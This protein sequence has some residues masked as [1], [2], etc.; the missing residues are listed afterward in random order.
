MYL[1]LE[2]EEQQLKLGSLKMTAVFFVRPKLCLRLLLAGE[3]GESRIGVGV[4]WKVEFPGDPQMRTMQTLRSAF[5]GS[6]VA[7]LKQN[8]FC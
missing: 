8:H 6:R 2:A 4:R 5:E 1:K 7:Q 3:H